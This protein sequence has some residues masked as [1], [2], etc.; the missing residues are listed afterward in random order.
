MAT[1]P[2][3]EHGFNVGK[4]HQL[5]IGAHA[6]EW[7]DFPLWQ[8]LSNQQYM[9]DRV[10]RRAEL[11]SLNHPSSRGAY[12]A[13]DM[14][15]LTGYQMIEIVNGPFTA[16]D[17]WDAAL[18][19]GRAVWAVANDDTHDLRDER[20]RAAGWNM[21][22]AASPSEADII[23]ALRGGRSYAGPA[24]GTTRGGQQH[25]AR[26]AHRRR[27]D[28]SRRTR[29]GTVHHHVHRCR[30]RDSPRGEERH[31]VVIHVDVRR[32][33]HTHGGHRS[34][35][36]ALSQSGDSLGWAQPPCTARDCE[37]GSHVDPTRHDPPRRP[38][39]GMEAPP[40]TRACVSLI[41][42]RRRDGV[43]A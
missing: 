18:S 13:D 17:V 16:E 4:T 1:L 6:V 12:D 11:V 5:A 7:F 29:G 15:R 33:V 38:L 3:Y 2:L 35:G 32:P 20:R 10:K 34:A 22:D 23:A 31:H 14:R 41:V 25:A 37:R 26:L 8:T 9:I 28:R 19:A 21:I 24:H 43:T 36:H 39:R 27:P 30:R 42:R 40:T